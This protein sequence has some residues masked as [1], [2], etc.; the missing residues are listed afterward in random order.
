MFGYN[1]SVFKNQDSSK[2]K[3]VPAC[4][5]CVVHASNPSV[6]Y[7]D[8]YYLKADK[9]LTY[10]VNKRK[11]AYYSALANEKLNLSKLSEFISGSAELKN[12]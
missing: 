6:K 8:E 3:D 12:N 9:P 10:N 1:K 7:V 2:Y 5:Y 4:Y 11:F